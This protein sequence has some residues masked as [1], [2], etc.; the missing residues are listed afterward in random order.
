VKARAPATVIDQLAGIPLFAGC[1][2]DELGRIA[3]LG[4]VV[5]R[6]GGTCLVGQDGV[7][8]EF[9]VLIRGQARCVVDDTDVHRFGPGDFFG[10]LALIDGGAR[11][12]AVV[13]EDEVEVLVLDRR[14]FAELFEISPVVAHNML[15]ELAR[16]LRS[17]TAQLRERA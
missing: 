12:A 5:A 2:R 16:R 4:T 13:S 11:T 7:G 3:Q 9:V 17:T 8:V 10:E 14:E 6:P 1:R 15:T